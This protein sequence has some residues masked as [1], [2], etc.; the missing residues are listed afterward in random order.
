MARLAGYGGNVYVSTLSVQNYNVA[1]SEF[2]DADVTLTLDTTDYKV[3]TGSNKMV[4]GAGL[5][6]GDILASQ[7]VALGDMSAFAVLY[8]FAKSSVNINA[9]DD[10]RLLL[11]NH[12]LCASPEV[13][14]SLPVLVANTWK[15]C[16]CPVA[17]GA[18]SAAT[19]V[20]SVGLELQANDPGAATMWID[21]IV[22][23][24]QIVGIRE[25][26]L[27]DVANVQDSTAFSDG[28]DKVFTVT[29]QQWSG[30]FS[31]F[32]DGAPLAK[33]SVVGL[34]LRESSTSTQMWRGAAIITNRRP[35]LSIDGLVGYSY[36][37]QGIHALEAPTA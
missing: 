10:Y 8:C 12:A 1:W 14:L 19:N 6:V 37:F 13:Q 32:K 29:S 24:N 15:F 30:S 4:Q 23:A 3:G 36:D 22:A 17:T 35:T 9:A 33:G 25:W 20:I 5:A 2:V 18:F 21:A 16:L 26:S 34:E 11:D 27:D 28:Q 31:G 7:V